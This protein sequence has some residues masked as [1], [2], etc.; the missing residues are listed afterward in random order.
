MHPVKELMSIV[1]T[2]VVILLIMIVK[3]RLVINAQ[4]WMK[5][6]QLVAFMVRVVRA[7]QIIITWIKPLA[8]ATSVLTV[9]MWQQTVNLV[10]ARVAQHA[11]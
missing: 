3:I 1:K 8:Q 4:V 9:Q 5:V 11:K 10:T 7:A 6:V 2:V